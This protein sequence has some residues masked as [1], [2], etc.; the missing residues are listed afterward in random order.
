MKILEKWYI[1]KRNKKE[2]T[3]KDVIKYSS[4]DGS[5]TLGEMLR[6]QGID[7]SKIS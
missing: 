5:S 6:A 2:S 1:K 3:K 7:L 4:G